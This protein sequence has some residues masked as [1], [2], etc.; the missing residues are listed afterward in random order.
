VDHC[1]VSAQPTKV[2]SDD[3]G[4]KGV[5]KRED[6]SNPPAFY[7][8][9]A[10]DPQRGLFY[11]LDWEQHQAAV[12]EIGQSESDWGVGTEWDVAIAKGDRKPRKKGQE[13]TRTRSKKERQLDKEDESSESGDS[14]D[15]YEESGTEGDQDTEDERGDESEDGESPEASEQEQDDQLRTPHKKR[16]RGH[17]PSSPRK[18]NATNSTTPRTPRK[19]RPKP[20]AHPTPHSK[21]ASKRRSSGKMKKLTLIVRP[22]PPVPLSPRKKSRISKLPQDPWLRAMHSLH[23]GARPDEV[24]LPCREEEYARILRSV[25][26]LLLE[27]SGGCVCESSFFSLVLQEKVT[28]KF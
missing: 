26:E 5:K 18:R 16:K 4:R 14:K 6:D 8:R 11:K 7:C 10:I 23:V 28:E 1:S 21:A 24:Q 13:K 2:A 19:P 3:R 20:T 22:P 27:G 17:T 12:L 25:E 9:L 15:A